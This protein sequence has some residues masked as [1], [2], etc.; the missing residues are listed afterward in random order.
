MLLLEYVHM[1]KWAVRRSTKEIQIKFYVGGEL[2][3]I[4]VFKSASRHRYNDED[5]APYLREFSPFI[6]FFRFFV[7]VESMMNE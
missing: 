4:C 7:F 6:F 2:S 3:F 5:V 1:E